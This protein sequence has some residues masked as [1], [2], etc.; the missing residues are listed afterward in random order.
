MR[1]EPFNS[2]IV[3]SLSLSLFFLLSLG[4]L[5]NCLFPRKKKK[6]GRKKIYFS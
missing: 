3:F 5:G 4:D 6:E 2:E 1:K